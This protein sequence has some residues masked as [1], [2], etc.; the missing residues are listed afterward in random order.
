MKTTRSKLQGMTVMIKDDPEYPAWKGTIL[1]LV[2]EFEGLEYYLVE[3]GTTE[4]AL[5][6]VSQI[7]SLVVCSEQKKPQQEDRELKTI[8][9][10]NLSLVQA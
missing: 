10:K 7:Y 4:K 2:R 3:L 6:P 1:G 5:I 8:S 9:K